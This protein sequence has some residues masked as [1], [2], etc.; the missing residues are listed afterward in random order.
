MKCFVQH[1]DPVKKIDQAEKDNLLKG[2]GKWDMKGTH[3]SWVAV[4][5]IST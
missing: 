5:L 3:M 1:L 4:T 2:K